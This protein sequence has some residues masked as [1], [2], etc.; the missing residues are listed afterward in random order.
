MACL[1]GSS[2]D[3]HRK[4]GEQKGREK[5]KHCLWSPL[6]LDE[7]FPFLSCLLLC[8]CACDCSALLSHCMSTCCITQAVQALQHHF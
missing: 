4:G 5:K 3:V 2:G 7:I 6:E 8:P 1:A